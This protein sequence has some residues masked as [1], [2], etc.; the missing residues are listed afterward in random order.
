M[1]IRKFGLRFIGEEVST[2]REFGKAVDLYA[3]LV[4]SGYV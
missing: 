2:E 3:I 1:Y 4:T